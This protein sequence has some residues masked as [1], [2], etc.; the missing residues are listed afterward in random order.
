MKIRFVCMAAAAVLVVATVAIPASAQTGT[1]VAQASVSVPIEGRFARGGQFAGTATVNRFEVRDNS[2]VAIG[3][4]TGTLRRGNRSVGSVI[5]GDVEWTVV[6][7]VNGI[8]PARSGAP[9]P[10]RL[11]PAY[12]ARAQATEPCPVVQIG[13]EAIDADLF[14]I[15][16][17]LTPIALDL[18]GDP[19]A[20]LG[21]LVCEVGDAIRN[22]AALVGVLNDILGLITGLLGGITGLVGG[23]VP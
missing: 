6:V 9:A 17:V 16:V 1:V 5:A 11:A 7:R 19:A 12:F 14:G 8:A 21:S 10:T 20:P 3:V 18:S 4:V 13:L 23:V 15:D 22:V 2:I